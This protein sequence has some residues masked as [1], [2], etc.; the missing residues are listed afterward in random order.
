MHHSGG[1]SDG[2][3]FLPGCG[4]PSVG[5]RLHSTSAAAGTR[6]GAS[7]AAGQPASALTVGSSERPSAMP[8][9]QVTPNRLMAVAISRPVNQSVRTLAAVTVSST[10]PTP[11]RVRP[12]SRAAKL[13]P[14]PHS[15][16]P[17]ISAA[18]P[19][20]STRSAPSRAE[21]IPLGSASTAPASM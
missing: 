4:S 18:N 3:G 1:L 12:A 16:L 21:I 5:T 2:A 6:Q 7:M 11:P 13:P 19:N 8:A 14:V 15:R 9:G 17:P 20:C 10:A